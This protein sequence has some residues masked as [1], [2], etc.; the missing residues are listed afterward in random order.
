MV[1]KGLRQSRFQLNI[2]LEFSGRKESDAS[3]KKYNHDSE[4][5]RDE[6]VPVSLSS[7]TFLLPVMNESYKLF[8]RTK[9]EG[10][11]ERFWGL[12]DWY[13]EDGGFD[14]KSEGASG[15][16]GVKLG[17]VAICDGWVGISVESSLFSTYRRRWRVLERLYWVFGSIVAWSFSRIYKINQK[18]SLK[19]H[20]LKSK[21]IWSLRGLHRIPNLRQ[22]LPN[23]YMATFATLPWLHLCFVLECSHCRLMAIHGRYREQPC[24]TIQWFLP[25]FMGLPYISVLTT[26]FVNDQHVSRWFDA[27]VID[28]EV[29]V[30]NR[31]WN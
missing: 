23:G 17:F 19:H 6:G 30:A 31:E 1:V 24:Q 18:I 27:V 16:F 3:T 13:D 12:L 14:K 7:S 26:T 9:S 10:E 4:N 29:Y 21:W 22:E 2:I 15:V 11:D 20:C 25:A 8:G 5:L 28:H